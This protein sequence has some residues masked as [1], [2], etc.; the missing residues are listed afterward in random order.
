MKYMQSGILTFAFLYLLWKI[1]TICRRFYFVIN[2]CVFSINSNTLFVEVLYYFKWN[3]NNSE[4]FIEI[5]MYIE[6]SH[7]ADFLPAE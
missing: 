2:E 4:M 1:Y 6:I 5:D 7:Q 3:D